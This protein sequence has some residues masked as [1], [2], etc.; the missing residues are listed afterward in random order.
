M[1]HLS[2]RGALKL[3]TAPDTTSAPVFVARRDEVF[4][5]I[6]L[7]FVIAVEVEDPFARG[8]LGTSIAR[9]SHRS[10]RQ[11]YVANSAVGLT[12]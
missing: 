11:A 9:R 12:K 2:A 7:D 6:R 1:P 3:S 5:G 10:S 4:E 8:D